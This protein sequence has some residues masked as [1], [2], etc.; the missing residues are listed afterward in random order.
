MATL[1]AAQARALNVSFI[2]GVENANVSVVADGFTGIGIP[3]NQLI[4][5]EFASY[6]GF[7]LGDL[8]SGTYSIGLLKSAGGELSDYLTVQWRTFASVPGIV[9]PVTQFS[10]FFQSDTDGQ[11]LAPPAGGLNTTAVEDGA[12]QSFTVPSP[13]FNLT[14]GMKSDI[15]A[16]SVPDA[17][18][19]I[20]L[21]GIGLACVI[22]PHRFAP[23]LVLLLD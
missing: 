13:A 22:T 12:L 1:M 14:V 23:R 15:E 8:G 7:Q 3:P 9:G 4:G 18:A 16:N 21:L 2:E 11:V 19:T 20:F 6:V 5:P 17:G 10:F